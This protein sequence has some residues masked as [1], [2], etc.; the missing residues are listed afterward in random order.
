MP[1]ASI[2]ESQTLRFITCGSVDDGKSTLIGRLL[3]ESKSL[4]EDQLTELAS[5]S[6]NFGSQ[7]DSLDFALLLDGLSIEREQGITIDVSYRYFATPARRFIVADTPGHEQYTRNMVTGASTADLAVLLVD[8][9]KG[10]LTQTLRHSF[11]VSLLGVRKVVV[12][13]NKLDL[14]GYSADIF[15]RIAKDYAYRAAAMGIKDPVCIPISALHGDNVVSGS[16][17]TPWYAGPTLLE[18]LESVEPE[19][20]LA[21]QP[22]R[23]PV[24][25]VIRAQPEFRGYA[26]R[27]VNGSVRPGDRIRVFPSG[28]ESTVARIVTFDGDL[29]AAEASRSVTLTLADDVDV[30]RGDMIV[31]HDAPPAVADQFEATLV[32]MDDA[33]LLHGRRYLL[34][35]GSRVVG[36]SVTR[37]KH[38]INV[39]TLE[40][41]AATQ[42]ALNEIGIA[43]LSLEHPIPFDPYEV[44]RDTGSFILIDPITHTTAG[45]GMIRFALRRSGN[46][47][48][49]AY[50]V[51][52]EARARQNGHKPCVVWLTGIS[53]SGKST[54]ANRVEHLLHAA[55]IHTYILDGDNVR[56]RLNRDLGFTDADRV[57]NIRRVAEVAHLMVDAGLVVLVAFISPF[58]AERRQARMLFDRS[59]FCE[60]F[61]DAPLE[62]AEQRDP[63]G[64]YKKARAGQLKNFTG[65][66]S[67]YE[68]P[69]APEVTI[70]T[71]TTTAD[72]AASTILDRL[73]SMG[74]FR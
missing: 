65:I 72:A 23:M 59:E 13:V 66:D 35:A 38:K 73:R 71:T 20:S 60:V 61:V 34:K 74:V 62:I 42:L 40:H 12:A 5:D 37:I 22:F 3:F 36:A 52:K 43:N 64:L 25:M 16:T 7:G 30:G 68:F 21:A 17:K 69:E 32:W 33:P 8:A 54:I 55:G 1:P 39:N 4:F 6:R 26:G 15:E 46:L 67:P 48:W 58:R 18:V 63:K 31:A 24:Q 10:I 50:E 19:D 47:R 70:D 56:S 28:R 51:D 44:S 41:M 9:R 14:V 11:L 27:I 29:D 57:E 53:G 49:Q 45:C 2:A